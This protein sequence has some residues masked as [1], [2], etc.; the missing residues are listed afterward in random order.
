MARTFFEKRNRPITDRPSTLRGGESI[1]D[2]PS[3]LRGGETGRSQI[4]HH[5]SHGS[6]SG[7][8]GGGADPGHGGMQADERG[9]RIEAAA[10]A[11]AD[12]HPNPAGLDGFPR[13]LGRYLDKNPGATLREIVEAHGR[14]LADADAW[15]DG[16]AP[17]LKNWLWGGDW[18][19]AP[20]KK[21]PPPGGVGEE[22]FECGASL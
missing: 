22:I 6:E 1:T 3:T 15:R 12:A 20:P 16:Y 10:R 2:R 8:E 18:R 17:K 21:K 19:R 9:R 11:M 7:Q 14:W 13:T 4:S 5:H